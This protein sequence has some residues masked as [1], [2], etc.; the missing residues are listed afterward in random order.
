MK[1]FLT[2]L[3]LASCAFAELVDVP[4][5]GVRVER[6]FRIAQ[7]AD[8]QLANDIWSMTLNPRGEIV[9]SGAGYIRTLLDTDGDGRMDKAVQFAEMKGAMG[10]CFGE[11][12]KQLL[13]MAEGWLS[14]YRDDNLDRVADAPPRRLFRFADSEHGGHAIRRGPDGW[15][16]VIGGNDAGIAKLLPAPAEGAPFLAG[17]LVRIAPDFTK[18]ELVAGGLRNP[19]DFDFDE[20][21]RVFTFDSDCER[22]YFLPWYSGCA[23]YEVLPG[24]HHGWRLAGYQRSFRVPDYMPATV[25]AVAD[26]GRGSP[27]GVVVSRS[28]QMPAHYRGGLFACDWTFGKI[29]HLP[30]GSTRP[31]V[32][33]EPIGTAGFAPT[34]IVETAD[35]ALLVSI[36]GRKTRGAVFRIERDGTDVPATAALPSAQVPRAAVLAE[37]ARAQDALGGWRLEGATAAAFVPYEPA[38]VDGLSGKDRIPALELGRAQLLSLDPR[39]RAEAARLLAMLE[40]DSWISTGRILADITEKSLATEDFHA[41]ACIARFRDEHALAVTA[42]IAQAILALDGKLA[43]GDHRPKQNWSVRLNEVVE[44]LIAHDPALA[45][46]LVSAEDFATP[47]HLALVDALPAASRAVAAEKFLVAVKADA[48]FE[49]SPELIKLIAPLADMR[50]LLRAKWSSLALR[51]ALR[52]VLKHN[53]AAEDTALIAEPPPAPLG[54]VPAFLASLKDIAW[55]KGD[56]TRGAQLFRDRAC[57][58]CHAG[59][60]PL[61]PELS[62]PVAR[63]SASDLMVEIQF[64]NRNI[65]EA[66]QATLFTLK[67]GTQ[68]NGLVAFAAADGVIIHTGPGLT[69]RLAENDIALREPSKT[70][71][72]PPAL[73][74]GLTP[75]EFAD[76]AAYL[77]TLRK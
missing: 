68:R 52:E 26:I 48:A 29:Y 10:L 44:R 50:P 76:L 46:A 77:R 8:E 39:I 36:G 54:D 62:G 72:M 57:A 53:A 47:G 56:T 70:S 37:I 38:K 51:P 49:W 66:Y 3:A 30:A 32:F 45:E 9:V 42:Q 21:G 4:T 27:T 24:R 19:Y 35:G 7:I 65:A 28:A 41:L 40:D 2:L 20:R 11:D 34:D 31:E 74:S 75:A 13:V 61:G 23:I 60:S 73:L 25:P 18:V 5:L 14:E 12:G 17:A 67:D 15:W 58:V 55:E 59:T 69:E 33:V 1:T 6:G 71:L 22:D 43:G 16:W 63:L 64:P